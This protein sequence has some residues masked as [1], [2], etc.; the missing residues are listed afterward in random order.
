MAKEKY[1]ST[2]EERANSIKL[3]VDSQRPM[4]NTELKEYLHQTYGD[5]LL[6]GIK[7]L[8]YSAI[9]KVVGSD[10][11]EVEMIVSLPTKQVSQYS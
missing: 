11:E 9:I 8:D 10:G 1:I 5:S 7:R 3:W 4:T 6:G 2:P